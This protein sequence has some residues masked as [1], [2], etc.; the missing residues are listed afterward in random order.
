MA[1]VAVVGDRCYYWLA[2]R[3]LGVQLLTELRAEA[4]KVELIVHSEPDGQPVLP[5]AFSTLRTK[6]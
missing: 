2:Q 5:A 1:A 6:A 4:S 3:S